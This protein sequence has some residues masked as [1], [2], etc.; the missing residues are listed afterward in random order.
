M[1]RSCVS[2]LLR[3]V[4]CR[5]SSGPQGGFQADLA[6]LEC[7]TSSSP[8]FSYRPTEHHTSTHPSPVILDQTTHRGTQIHIDTHPNNSNKSANTQDLAKQS[9]TFSHCIE[10]DGWQEF[11][12]ILTW[13]RSHP[14][15]SRQLWRIAC[16]LMPAYL[17][18]ISAMP[19]WQLVPDPMDQWGLFLAPLS[20]T[21][22]DV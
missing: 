22:A 11:G 15:T 13:N 21:D 8:A 12:G 9:R 3:C 14:V 2:C 20:D 4:C 7:V 1:D 5:W 10:R 16:I 18:F 17:I 6:T 19:R